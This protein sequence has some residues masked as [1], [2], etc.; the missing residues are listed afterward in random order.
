[1]CITGSDVRKVLVGWPRCPECG[2]WLRAIH[3]QDKRG[4]S[5][6]RWWACQNLNSH[7]RLVV[8]HSNAWCQYAGGFWPMA[9]HAHT[10][11]PAMPLPDQEVVLVV[12]GELW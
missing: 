6:G 7:D 11:G 10:P 3:L 4:E 8:W 5:L 12:Q 2:R 9:K 1:M